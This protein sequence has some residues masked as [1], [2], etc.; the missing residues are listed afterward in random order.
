M[1]LSVRLR[2][3]EPEVQHVN[4]Q[5]QHHT[6]A[7]GR[8]PVRLPLRWAVILTIAASTGMPAGAAGG[9]VAVVGGFF[10]TATAMHLMI[11]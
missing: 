6:P 7:Q 4:E 1:K 9:P 8:Q 10:A 3:A 11:D 2:P 5:Q